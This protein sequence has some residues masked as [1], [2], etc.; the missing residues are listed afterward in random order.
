MKRTLLQLV[1]SALGLL[2]AVAA[3]NIVSVLAIAMLSGHNVLDEDAHPLNAHGQIAVVAV[4]T[5]AALGGGYVASLI[6]RTAKLLHSA[7]FA[8]LLFAEAILTDPYTSKFV[9]T[10]LDSALFA[11]AAL[12]GGAVCVWTTRGRS[13]KNTGRM[14]LH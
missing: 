2:V 10:A 14:T 3:F 11:V 12:V 1:R 5:V 4:F 6:G 7:L 9:F 13:P 8:G